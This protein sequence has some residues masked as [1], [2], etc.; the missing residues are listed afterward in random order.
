MDLA[1]KAKDALQAGEYDVAVAKYTEALAQTPSAVPY[2]IGRSTAYQ[3]SSPPNLEAALKDAEIAV[4][5]ATKRAKRELI[6]EAQQ[7]RAVTLFALGQYANAGY[8][9][10]LVKKFNDKDKTVGVWEIKIQNKLKGIAE[11]DEARKVTAV[12][13]PDTEP[14]AAPTTTKSEQKAP[15]QP[16]APQQ[17]P[18]DKV[19]HEWYTSNDNIVISLFAKGVPEDK[20]VVDIE[21][22]SLS[23]SF[24]VANSTTYEFNL[25]PLFAPIV[26]DKSTFNVTPTKVEITLKKATPG[27]KWSKLESSDESLLATA[28]S[29]LAAKPSA[30]GPSYPT[31]SRSGPKD[32]DKLASELTQKK[33]GKTEAG[34]DEFDDDDDGGDPANAFFRKLYKN[35]DPDTRRA[36]MKS[37]QESNGTAL[38]TNWSEVSKA[39]VETSPPEGMEAKKWDS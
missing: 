12:D 36:M 4:N 13:V 14:D 31:S 32:W 27:L 17:T 5:L 8:V 23:V 29:T 22:R 15:A 2:Y 28:T 21:E 3:R 25:D 38:S 18:V 33:D 26:V 19:R 30:S 10:G 9:F 24:P 11:D 39:P 16:A 7:R 37:Y 6:A 20:V 34:E 1:S 35:A